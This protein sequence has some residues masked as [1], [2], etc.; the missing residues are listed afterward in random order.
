MFVLLIFARV[1][2]GPSAGLADF[3]ESRNE[4][5]PQ[6]TEVIRAT[7][8]TAFS[9]RVGTW[10][11]SMYSIDDSPATDRLNDAFRSSTAVVWRETGSPL[12]SIRGSGQAARSLLLFEGIPLN[13]ADGF[14]APSLLVPTE[15][16]SD[17][18]LIAGPAG[19][20][21]GASALSGAVNTRVRLY[22]STTARVSI[23]TQ[24]AGLAR[25]E[26]FLVAPMHALNQST[27][28]SD[29]AQLSFSL[30]NSP[31]EFL[32]DDARSGRRMRRQNQERKTQRLTVIGQQTK[33]G[34]RLNQTL[35][36]ASGSGEDA[37][38]VLTPRT[39]SF[40]RQ[41]FVAAFGVARQILSSIE[42]E[43]R[44]SHL[45][46]DSKDH[47]DQ[48][49][50]QST[51]QRSQVTLDLEQ[52]WSTSLSTQTFLDF[53]WESLNSSGFVNG[54]FSDARQA[55]GTSANWI[56][57]ERLDTLAAAR[58]LPDDETLLK[59]LRLRWQDRSHSSWLAYSEGFRRPSLFDRFALSQS[60]IANPDLRA[61]SS[62]QLELGLLLESEQAQR[63]R[64]SR[65]A[66]FLVFHAQI[67]NTFESLVVSPG[68]FT[69]INRG[70]TET[71]GFE[72]ELSYAHRALTLRA[73]HTYLHP[74]S[75]GEQPRLLTPRNR[76]SFALQ[77]G[78]G[79]LVGE[80]KL[81]HQAAVTDLNPLNGQSE[82]I[83]EWTIVDLHVRSLAL[84]QFEFR[85]G[86][87]NFFDRPR[88]L[89][90]GF[91][92]PQRSFYASIESR[93]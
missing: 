27:S 35:L 14:G 21:Y 58:W 77:Q 92:E 4:I 2:L 53:D 93:F 25:S 19:V 3:G 49:D 36:A 41:G 88:E 60:F 83:P 5:Q 23:Q 59:N 31:G 86:V 80:A 75:R 18:H 68:V 66:K 61:E 43:M 10:P 9:K 38:S 6:A 45:L 11:V 89:S 1:I 85:V 57:N 40:E 81:T 54:R 56:L 82:M 73:A 76:V 78:F 32:F 20:F 28:G 39:S 13:F 90:Y 65:A 12:L 79:F 74:L 63:R 50:A 33:S 69:K 37:D 16:L 42:A 44:L 29:V 84:N 17:F 24:D 70:Q 72:T 30:Q 67:K 26:V 64:H 22:D 46:H 7:P 87:L 15:L 34:Y 55:L 8:L 91:P 47:S 48:I 52:V 62:R 51:S 71:N